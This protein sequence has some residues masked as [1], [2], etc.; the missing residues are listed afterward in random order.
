[1]VDNGKDSKKPGKKSVDKVEK[2][3]KDDKGKNLEIPL[4]KLA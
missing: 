4:K 1:M 2:H 3:V